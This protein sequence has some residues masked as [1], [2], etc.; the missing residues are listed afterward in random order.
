[1][2]CV[3]VEEEWLIKTITAWSRLALFTRY[4]P[5]LLSTSAG[6]HLD[7]ITRNPGISKCLHVWWHG[8]ETSVLL[9]EKCDFQQTTEWVPGATACKSPSPGRYL[10]F[11]GLTWLVLFH[12]SSMSCTWIFLPTSPH[13]DGHT[14]REAMVIFTW[15]LHLLNEWSAYYVHFHLWI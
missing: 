4:M 3:L 10:W 11:F 2:I 6:G 14:L 8:A 13:K 7:L 5:T 15:V 1:M 12:V 9:A